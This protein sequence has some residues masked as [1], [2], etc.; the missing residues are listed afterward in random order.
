VV[1]A[2]NDLRICRGQT[3][4][5]FAAGAQRYIWGPANGLSCIDCPSPVATP[6]T[7]TRYAVTGFNAF[8][9]SSTDSV[10]VTVAQPFDVTATPSDSLCIGQGIQ[11]QANGAVSYQWS[12]AAGLTAANIA[13]PFARPNQSTTYRVVGFDGV[14][15]FTDTVFVRLGVGPIPTLELGQGALVVAG[16]R[17]TL[18]PAT[19]GGIVRDYA[20]TPARQL[21]CTD[22]RNPVATIDNDINYRLTITNNYGCSATD[23]ISYRIFCQ[24]DQVF[25]PNAFSPDGDGINDQVY[26]MGKGVSKVKSFRIFTRFGALIYEKANFDINDPTTGWD[27]RINGVAASPD[28]YVYTAEVLCTGGSSF[29]YKGNITLFR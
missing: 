24:A 10:L 13:D 8:G 25:I 19:T 3:T 2:S 27:G 15:C 5:L 12:P 7:T 14:N 20:W 9:C 29:T 11:L 23:T 21:S 4:I 6:T 26:V 1:G 16:T 28:V 17:I 22:C 18:N